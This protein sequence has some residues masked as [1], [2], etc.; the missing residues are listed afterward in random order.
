MRSSISN[1][2]VAP[3]RAF[4]V[5]RGGKTQRSIW[6]IVLGLMLIA[7]AAEFLTSLAVNH[8][9]K[10]L[11]RTQQEYSDAAKLKPF[12]ASGT[13]TVLLLGNSLLRDSIDYPVLRGALSSEYDV[14][15]LVFEQT[16]YIDQFYVLRTLLRN[17]ARPREVVLCISVNHLLG[18]ET[19]GEFMS[20]YMD[21]SDVASL[22]RR[23][24]LD[25]TT[26]SS[27]MFAHWSEWYAFRAD[28]RKAV[29]GAVLPNVRDLVT[30]LGWRRPA[31]LSADEVRFKAEPRLR[32]LKTLCDQYH[33][34]LTILVPPALS[35][36]RSDVVVSL[37]ENI[38]LR[39]LIPE[40]PGAL[41]AD[42]F[43]D[44]FHLNETGAAIFTGKV[45]S[46]L[47]TL[48]PWP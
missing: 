20:R 3:S 46:E 29:L 9:S 4:E 38:G 22:G 36:D 17:G 35:Q 2:E 30:T 19:R 18:N 11:R 23:L 44:G 37:G 45:Q 16:E 1:S 21:A 48:N 12:S 31:P 39:V 47:V 33:V 8:V 25:A 26:V 27:L 42:L 40:Q 7:L 34:Q 5:I 6:A 28:T 10:I 43:Q 32:E 15:R 24:H 41:N 14:H 13:P